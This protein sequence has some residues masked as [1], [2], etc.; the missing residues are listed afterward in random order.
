MMLNSRSL[1]NVNVLVYTFSTEAVLFLLP[2][3]LHGLLPRPFLYSEL[4]GFCF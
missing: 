4:L 3:C 1:P 2:E